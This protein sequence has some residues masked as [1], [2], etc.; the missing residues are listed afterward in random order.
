VKRLQLITGALVLALWAGITWV[1]G[2]LALVGAA[3]TLI[4]GAGMVYR[5]Y[6]AEEEARQR[7]GRIRDAISKSS[8][9]P[10]S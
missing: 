9:P 5:R 3:I 6:R 8:R 7:D 4:V 2:P 1:V 10:R